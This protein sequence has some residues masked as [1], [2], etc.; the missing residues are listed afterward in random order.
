M[1]AVNKQDTDAIPTPVIKG[2]GQKH[3]LL[4]LALPGVY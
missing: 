1:K 2:E 3:A 4:P